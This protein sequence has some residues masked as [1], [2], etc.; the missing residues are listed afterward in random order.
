MIKN[1][2]KCGGCYGECQVEIIADDESL[3][4]VMCEYCDGTGEIYIGPSGEPEDYLGPE[5]NL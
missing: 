3:M 2:V 5:E 1:Y 4:W